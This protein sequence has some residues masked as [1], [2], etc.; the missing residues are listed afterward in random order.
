MQQGDVSCR[1]RLEKIGMNHKM[2]PFL[3]PYALLY[4]TCMPIATYCD[5]QTH[6]YA[7]PKIERALHEMFYT[8]SAPCLLDNGAV[9]THP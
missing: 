8:W 2:K 5:M 3:F 7:T 4:S 6:F 1:F 9:N